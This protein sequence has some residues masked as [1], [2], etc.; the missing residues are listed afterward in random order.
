MGAYG[1]QFDGMRDEFKTCLGC[2]GG[3]RARA[4]AAGARRR[5]PPPAGRMEAGGGPSTADRYEKI[6]LLGE[7]TFGVVSKARDLSKPAG[8]PSAVVAIKKVR[9]GNYKDGVSVTALREIKLLQEIKHPNVIAL[10]D[11]FASRA[12]VNM[13]LEY[14]LTD[15]EE[16][17][18]DRSVIL[19]PAEIKCCMQQILLGTAACH[20]AYTLHRD[21]KPSNILVGAD[22]RLKLADFG[23]ARVHG[24]PN[25]RLTHQVITRWYR[26]PELLFSATA[27]G[28]AVDVW[29]IGCI[30][31]ELMLRMPYLPGD[32]DLDQLTKIFHARGSPTDETWPGRR[33]LPAYIDFTPS[34][35]PDHRQ[36]FTASSPAALALLDEMLALDPLRRPSAAA[37][38]AHAYFTTEAPAA[39]SADALLAKIMTSN[40]VKRQAAGGAGAAAPANGAGT[41]R[42]SR[43]DAAAGDGTTLGKRKLQFT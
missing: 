38:A 40:T 7:G 42:V 39:C 9:M 37:L 27:Y 33:A 31:A 34:P 43:V 25:P 29:S 28:P 11:V 5:R 22:G 10:V 12:N 30:F 8:S 1:R 3:A 13:V 20:A 23:L 17:V 24:S 36:L 32:S 2:A 26:P 6:C 14:C 16:V 4:A 19:T 21:L 41:V 15:L 35:P 18:K